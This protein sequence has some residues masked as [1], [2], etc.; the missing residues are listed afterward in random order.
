MRIST[1]QNGK[2]AKST[3]LPALYPFDFL[4]NNGRLLT[5]TVSLLEHHLLTSLIVTEHILGNLP[6]IV[7][8]QA[9]GSLDNHLSGTIVLLKFEKL[10]VII[11]LGEVEN[12][13]NVGPPEPINA[14][15]I[16]A[17]GTYTLMA[18]MRRA[19]MDTRELHYYG[20]LCIVGIL[21]LIYKHIP[22]TIHILLPHILMPGKQQIRI[23]QQVVKIHGIGL[24]ATLSIA[25]VHVF[26]GRHLTL[27]ILPHVDAGRVIMRSK[28]IVFGQATEELLYCFSLSPISLIIVFINDL[29]S[30]W[31]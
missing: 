9:V 21:I 17:N 8:D 3:F 18:T 27:Y 7:P 30:P 14:L 29:E 28:E 10:G 25:H 26:H 15:R 13:V 1:V 12:V 11:S 2:I 16:V 31:S 4:A 19:F 20:L 23:K 22:E 5:V 24:A 6:C